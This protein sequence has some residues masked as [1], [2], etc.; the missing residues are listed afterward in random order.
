MPSNESNPF[1]SC[2]V[3]TPSPDLSALANAFSTILMRESLIGGYNTPNRL[4]EKK[5]VYRNRAILTRS[6]RRNS[7]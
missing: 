5:T 4:F 2:T 3:R 7:S 6:A 1:K